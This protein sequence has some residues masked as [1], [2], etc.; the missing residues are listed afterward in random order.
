[1]FAAAA[2]LGIEPAV[3][4]ALTG[5]GGG[6]RIFV[7]AIGPVTAEA[8]EGRGIGVGI[9]PLQPRMA[10]LAAALAALPFA[11][12]SS[13]RPEPLLLDAA[14]RTVTGP[15]GAV[16]LTDLQFALVASLARRPGMTCPTGV[17][18]REVWGAG[19]SSDPAGRRRLEVLASRLRSR[20]AAI[21][22]SVASVPKRGYRLE[23][24][25]T[26]AAR[27]S[28]SGELPPVD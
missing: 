7:A 25:E 21:G 26:A 18:L 17:L 19:L 13:G 24:A 6:R 9:C 5:T 10:A 4:A 22:V 3:E 27:P 12:S 23:S 28:V 8:L 15:A 14:S 16:E 2:G 1:V 11:F 20:L